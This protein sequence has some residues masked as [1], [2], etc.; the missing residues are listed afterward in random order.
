MLV[1]AVV[2]VAGLILAATALGATR[3]VI[4]GPGLTPLMI[5]VAARWRTGRYVAALSGAVLTVLGVLPLAQ[6]GEVVARLARPNLFGTGLDTV[7]TVLAPAVLLVVGLAW[8]AVAVAVRAGHR[9]LLITAGWLGAL[10]ALGSVLVSAGPPMYTLLRS[11]IL[12]LGVPAIAAAVLGLVV[13]IWVP[14]LAHQMAAPMPHRP[15]RPRAVL[16][17]ASIAALVLGLTTL[18]IARPHVQREALAEIFPDG[19]LAACIADAMGAE[20]SDAKVTAHELTEI[21]SLDCTGASIGNL[22][23]M[24]RLTNL[25]SLELWDNEVADLTPLSD[26]E[27]LGRLGLTNN[28]VADLTPLAQL[29]VLGDVGLSGNRI[30][31]LTPLAGMTSIH[32]LGLAD[33]GITDVT[34]L[35]DLDLLAELDL[36]RNRIEEASPLAGL[37]RLVRL[38]LTD[39]QITDPSPLG[40]LPLL[41]MFDV[42]RNEIPDAALFT[43]FPELTE[44]W[45]GENPLTD[46]APLAQ[47]PSLTG[48]D[49]RGL[50]EVA[51][52][53]ILEA[54]GVYVGG[55]AK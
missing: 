16:I 44:L 19:A 6:H 39:N 55:G 42:S 50:G 46:L 14:R 5:V 52:R 31:D 11:G 43:G 18:L 8:V 22:T 1:T 45:V 38:T 13:A 12:E 47:L 36:S 26:L 29:P 25:A 23:G 28:T 2:A 10:A 20:G 24:E 35:A 53:D 3:V 40:E 34:P 54:R 48:V 37:E 21:R 27:K 51:G 15:I 4:A 49:I 9:R 7:D 17:T 41:S 32:H 30:N 33:N